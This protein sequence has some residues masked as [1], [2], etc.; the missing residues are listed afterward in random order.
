MWMI[1]GDL[2]LSGVEGIER[3][4][5]LKPTVGGNSGPRAQRFVAPAW[6]SNGVIKAGHR[7]AE[8]LRQWFSQGAITSKE[9]RWG[10]QAW[11]IRITKLKIQIISN[12]LL[13]GCTY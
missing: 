9:S 13:K 12:K 2:G 6:Q 11:S 3:T 10:F 4:G 5:F 1:W 7:T 8:T